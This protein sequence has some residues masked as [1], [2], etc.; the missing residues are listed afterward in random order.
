MPETRIREDSI[1]SFKLCK[2]ISPVIEFVL[3]FIEK[4]YRTRKLTPIIT[5]TGGSRLVDKISVFIQSPLPLWLQFWKAK[6]MTWQNERAHTL[7]KNDRNVT[8]YLDCRRCLNLMPYQKKG[9]QRHELLPYYV[10]KFQ[11]VIGEFFILIIVLG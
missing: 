8:L 9:T 5:K 3:G 10:M 6:V 7:L 1:P 4:K 2:I 11:Q